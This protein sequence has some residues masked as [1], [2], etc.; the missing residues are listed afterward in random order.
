MC[1]GGDGEAPLAR[2]MWPMPPPIGG[3][4][5]APFARGTCIGAVAVGSP[6]PAR[7]GQLPGC[8]AKGSAA[9][10]GGAPANGS[11]SGTPPS[12]VGGVFWPPGPASDGPGGSAAPGRR[13]QPAEPRLR[14]PSGSS[15][16]APT[17]AEFS[18]PPLPFVPA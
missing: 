17:A 15:S 13:T 5:D 3:E 9:D 14:L 11:P 8:G 6:R 1:I 18:A 7:S 4:G 16:P 10:G 12:A 2:G